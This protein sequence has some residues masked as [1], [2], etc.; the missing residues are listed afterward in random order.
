M[1]NKFTDPQM[2]RDAVDFNK[3]IKDMIS[4]IGDDPN[5]E[6]C[7]GTPNRVVNSW[8]ELYSG[9]KKNPDET[10]GTV[11]SSDGYNQMVILKDVEIYSTCSHHMIPFYGKAHIAYIPDKKVVGL[12]KLARLAEV[13]SRRLQVQER[14]TQQIA[15]TLMSVLQPKGVMVVIEAKH[16]CMCA[17]GISKQNSIMITSA[18]HGVFKDQTVREEFLGLIK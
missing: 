2:D 17:R 4:F 16:M 9:Y 5:S 7:I 10:L 15:D 1:E 11:F 8:N 3:L 18:I 13:F 12:S 14:L 6:H